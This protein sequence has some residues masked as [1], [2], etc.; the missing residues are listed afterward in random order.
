MTLGSSCGS[1]KFLDVLESFAVQYT[2][3][4]SM[5]RLSFSTDSGPQPDTIHTKIRL[6]KNM[7]FVPI[8]FSIGLIIHSDFTWIW[9]SERMKNTFYKCI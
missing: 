6:I 3:E 7:D 2:R 8:K 1:S 4:L 5:S 9:L